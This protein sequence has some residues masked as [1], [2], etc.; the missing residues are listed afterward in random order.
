MLRCPWP[1]R[2]P[3]T[4]S[5][6]SVLRRSAT[7]R[8]DLVGAAVH[9]SQYSATRL[10]AA[11]AAW[12][13]VLAPCGS[14]R[15]PS[16]VDNHDQSSCGMHSTLRAVFGFVCLCTRVCSLRGH[17]TYTSSSRT[18]NQK[19][20]CKSIAKITTTASQDPLREHDSV[21]PPDVF[22]T[23]CYHTHYRGLCLCGT[24]TRRQVVGGGSHDQLSRG[25]AP[26]RL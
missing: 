22:S 18:S 8:V 5:L 2:P 6:Y 25:C 23:Q 26:H 19:A 10:P 24:V 21:L 9:A 17:G 14:N 13:A 7:S 12:Y 11:T 4:C 20:L 1:P 15:L 3:M 16:D